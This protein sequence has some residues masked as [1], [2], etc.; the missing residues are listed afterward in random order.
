MEKTFAR[1]EANLCEHSA[2][3]DSE[4]I[5]DSL[6]QAYLE[7]ENE[8]SLKDELAQIIQSNQQEQSDE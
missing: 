7:E 2:H 5:I 3:L 8:Q 6:E 4:L 1:W